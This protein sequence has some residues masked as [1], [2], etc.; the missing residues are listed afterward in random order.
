MLRH[1]KQQEEKMSQMRKTGY[2]AKRRVAKNP[3]R[4]RADS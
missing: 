3:K 2:D 1:C 4:V